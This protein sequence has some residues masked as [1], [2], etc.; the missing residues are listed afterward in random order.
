MLCWFERLRL[1]L[2]FVSRVCLECHGCEVTEHYPRF[3][4]TLFGVLTYEWWIAKRRLE[5]MQD[6]HER[7]WVLFSLSATQFFFVSFMCS[8]SNSDE[9]L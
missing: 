2:N 9:V 3:C 5:I 7:I 6:L 4:M 1:W 8:A